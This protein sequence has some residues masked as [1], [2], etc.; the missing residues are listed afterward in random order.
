[1]SMF[2]ASSCSGSTA[3]FSL[4]EL[5]LVV[6]VLAILGSVGSAYYFNVIK[7]IEMNTTAAGVIS[8]LNHA[9]SSA[10]AG[11][12]GVRWGVHFVN[13]TDDLYQLF[14]TPTDFASASTTIASVV[15]LPQQ[16]VFSDP[17]EGSV[18]DVLFE[19]IAGI[20][21]STTITLAS[22]DSTRIITVPAIG[23]AY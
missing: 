7:N 4:L 5:L 6:A 11:E 17:V 18:R 20:T 12:G 1:M 23:N 3:G 14:S 2:R 19:R 16:V 22:S 8:D 21:A 15:Y 13:G 10:M 9:Q